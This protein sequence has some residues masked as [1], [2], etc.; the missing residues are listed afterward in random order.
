MLTRK[1]IAS[2]PGQLLALGVA[3]AAASGSAQ[4]AYAVSYTEITNFS[5]TGAS[6]LFDFTY[7]TDAAAEEGI[8]SDANVA[9]LDAD[10][11]CIGCGYNN[12][13]VA[14]GESGNYAYGDAKIFNDIVLTGMGAA[15]SIGEV[16]AT[17]T[18]GFADGTNTLTGFV[19]TTGNLTFSFNA[20][21]YQAV[22]AGL[23][24]ASS[25]MSVTLLDFSNVE[26]FRWTPNGDI[27]SGIVN[28]TEAF[29]DFNLNLGIA[30]NVIYNPGTGLYTA[31]TTSLAA[32]TYKINITMNNHAVAQAVPEAGTW[33]MMAAGLGLV[34]FGVRRRRFDLR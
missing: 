11:A 31:S 12:S 32:G 6:N 26:I 16:S 3:M 1:F 14:H 7:S 21:P 25:S 27:G 34:A 13:F 4:A 8:G 28:G 10:P 23:A 22:S 29:D 19:S 9:T 5:V 30:P 15:S 17:S 33:A 18:L 2:L 24:T 20:N